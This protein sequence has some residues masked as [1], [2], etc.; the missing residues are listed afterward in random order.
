MW[1][2]NSADGIWGQLGISN[3]R[4]F[5]LF[6]HT[7]RRPFPCQL[8]QLISPQ[9]LSH[10]YKPLTPTFSFN[11]LSTVVCLGYPTLNFSIPPIVI[12][13]VETGKRQ[14]IADLQISD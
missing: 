10:I 5:Y 1:Q 12:F 3:K 7:V 11:F 4:R 13:L 14:N 6:I 9:L 2:V 8:L